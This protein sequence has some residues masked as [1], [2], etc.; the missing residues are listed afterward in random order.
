M[1]ESVTTVT[2]IVALNSSG[3]RGT[4]HGKYDLLIID[5]HPRKEL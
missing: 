3:F 1:P 5:V 2:H 4:L